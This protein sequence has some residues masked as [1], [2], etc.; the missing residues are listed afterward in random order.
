MV[1]CAYCGKETPENIKFCP[2]CGGSPDKLLNDD[3]DPRQIK[4]DRYANLVKSV[5][6]ISDIRTN[7]VLFSSSVSR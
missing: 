3:Y 2:F 4:R 6:H 7:T 1:F 5:N